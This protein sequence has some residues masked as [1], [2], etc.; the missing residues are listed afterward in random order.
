LSTW[1]LDEVVPF[2]TFDYLRSPRVGMCQ[3]ASNIHSRMWP[4][5]LAGAMRAW[6]SRDFRDVGTAVRMLEDMRCHLLQRG[7]GAGPLRPDAP[8]KHCHLPEH[9]SKRHN[10]M[11]WDAVWAEQQTFYG[12]EGRSSSGKRGLRTPSS[13]QRSSVQYSTPF[14][15]LSFMAVFFAAAMI[16]TH[17]GFL[18]NLKVLGSRSL[19][20]TD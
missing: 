9:I 5:A 16:R 2:A 7:I 10:N 6:G 1:L 12:E 15:T 3:D 8:P 20:R 11:H 19:R 4:R 14:L 17:W 13:S 18:A